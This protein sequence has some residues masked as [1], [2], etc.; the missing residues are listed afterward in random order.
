LLIEGDTA[1]GFKRARVDALV[2]NLFLGHDR[3]FRQGARRSRGVT[4]LPG[5]DVIGMLARAVRSTGFVFEVV[6]QNR[7]VRGH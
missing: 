6:A 4:N 2:D 3:G 1:A 5:K 7:R